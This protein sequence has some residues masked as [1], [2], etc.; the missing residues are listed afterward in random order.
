MVSDQRTVPGLARLGE[1]ALVGFLTFV[2]SLPLITI[3]AAQA[4]AFRALDPQRSGEPGL[5]AVYLQA[6]RE[7]LRRGLVL[8]MVW[9]L[10]ALIGGMDLWFAVSLDSRVGVPFALLGGTLIIFALAIRSQLALRLAADDHDRVPML[11]RTSLVIAGRAPGRTLV[12]VL[13]DLSCLAAGLVALVA[14]PVVGGISLAVQ[15]RL[16]EPCRSARVVTRT[17]GQPAGA[18]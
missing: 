3:T 18:R 15:A 2:C 10:P 8:Q 5:S 11:V 6:L 4:A 13:A 7:C 17:V 16:L 9:A 12:I 1:I 14:L